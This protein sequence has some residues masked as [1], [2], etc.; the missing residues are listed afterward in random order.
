VVSIKEHKEKSKRLSKPI[1]KYIRAK[2]KLLTRA[3]AGRMKLD[4]DTS[5]LTKKMVVD[6]IHI[7]DIRIRS[8]IIEVMIDKRPKIA[9]EKSHIGDWEIGRLILL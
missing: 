7:S 1:E 8:I 5:T 3:I 4:T 6:S 9:E 2:V